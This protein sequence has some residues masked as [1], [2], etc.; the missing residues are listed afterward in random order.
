MAVTMT[1]MMSFPHGVVK[2]PWKF[3]GDLRYLMMFMLPTTSTRNG[4]TSNTASTITDGLALDAAISLNPSQD[5]CNVA[6]SLVVEALS[7]FCRIILVATLFKSYPIKL[8]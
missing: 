3:L 1:M 8:G 6:E 2:V 7:H 4:K 5:L